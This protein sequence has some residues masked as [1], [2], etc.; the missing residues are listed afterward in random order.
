MRVLAI[1]IHPDDVEICI[2]GTVALLARRGDEVAVLDLTRGES[3][4]NGTPEQRAREAEEASRVLGVRRRVNAALPD[5]GLRSGDPEQ[6]RAIVRVLRAERPQVVLLPNADDPHPDHAAGGA[7]SQHAVFLSNVN[8]YPTEDGGRRQERWRVARVLV[9]GGRR[10]VRPDVVVDVTSVYE[11]KVAAVRAHASQVGG[12]KD[13][14][15]TPLTDPRFL[16]GVQASD[17]VAG[18][19][20]GATYGEAFQLVA[21]IAL[22]DFGPLVPPEA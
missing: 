2:G 13:A 15:T 16:S 14:L 3:S 6:V 9:Y 22:G 1:G 11:I 8:G 7:L 12:G 4:T 18:R 21:P 10:D 20:V 17:R 19:R 5:T